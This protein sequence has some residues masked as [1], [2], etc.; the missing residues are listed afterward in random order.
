MT[1]TLAAVLVALA[2]LAVLV[3]MLVCGRYPG[4]R[5][6][7]RVRRWFEPAA[8]SK[9]RPLARPRLKLRV[10]GARGSALIATN[11]AGRAPPALLLDQT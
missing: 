5:A 9:P 7:E 2:P 3:G 8:H 6:L 10:S 1:P 4:E 11:L